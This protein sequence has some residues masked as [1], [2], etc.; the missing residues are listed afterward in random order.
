MLLSE[1]LNKASVIQVVGSPEITEIKK[2][3]ID[4]RNSEKGSMFFAINGFKTNGHDFIPQ[5]VSNG[6][7]AIVM[8]EDS[9]AIDQLLTNNNVVKILV[10][11]SRSALSQFANV[12]YENP[13]SKLSLIGITG[14]K[15]KTTTSYYLKN[16]FDLAG[17]KSGL[18]G[19]NKNMIGAKEVETKLTTPEAHII[20]ELMSKMVIEK[21]SNCVME[22]SSHSVELGRVSNL[23]FDIG[24]FTNI[25]SDH[26]DFHK[27]FDNYLNAKKKFFD[28]LKPSAKVVFNSDDKNANELLKDVKCKKYSYSIERNSN[29]KIN[30]LEYDL[31][32]TRFSLS[33]SN[34]NYDVETKLIGIFNAYNATAAIGS[35]INSNITVE[36]AIEGIYKTPQV[37]GRFEVLTS[38]EKKVIVDYSHTA[39][40]LDQ[41]LKAIKHIV[42][43]ERPIYT[44][45]GCGGDRDKTKR[46]VMGSIAVENSNFVYVT[47]DNPRSEDPYDIIKDI[48]SNLKASNFK[49]IEDREI[50]IK[51]AITESE[52]NAVILIAGKGHENYQEINGVRNYFSDKA[53]AEK[54]M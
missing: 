3:S 4:S 33:L 30:N 20:N 36:H 53:V 37:P 22:V 49:V 38:G 13:S 47:S 28:R 12:L 5:A 42:K 44:V 35:A 40:S 16:I 34:K 29:L 46:P 32:G 50:A 10:Q 1:I 45:F 51:S 2:I 19:T 15:G 21:C 24:V 39:D 18:I 43:D 7:S 54:Y 23:D 26:L 25:T 27:T 17:L 14:T 8:D 31:E 52:A 11:N 6:V 41:A 9:F 48:T